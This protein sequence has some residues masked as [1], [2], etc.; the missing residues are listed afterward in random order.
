MKKRIFKKQNI[1]IVLSIL[2]ITGCC[3]FYGGRFVYY[4]LDS[5]KPETDKSFSALLKSNNMNNKNFKVISTSYYF[6]DS[7][8]DNYVLYSGVLFRAFKIDSEER[9]YLISDSSVTSLAMG[10]NKIFTNS[11]I[12]EWLNKSNNDNSGILSKNLVTS[13]LVNTRVCVD[14]KDKAN[15]NECNKYVSDYLIGLLDM[16]DYINMGGSKSF[17]NT[18][19]DFYLVNNNGKKDWYVTNSGNVAL[20]DGTNVIGVKPVVSLK[21]DIQVKSGSGKKD[22]PYVIDGSYFGSY[23]KLG[24]DTWRVIGEEENNLRLLLTDYLKV[25]GTKLEYAYSTSNY[26]YDST[27]KNTLAYYLNHTYLNSLS[28]ENVIISSNYY[29]G[30]YGADNDYDYKKTFATTVKARVGILSIG[31]INLN[32]FTNTALATGVNKSGNLVY[33]TSTNSSLAK[34]NVTSDLNVVPVITISKSSLKTGDGTS[35]KPYG[36]E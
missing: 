3:I 4:Y 19:E 15:N 9:I 36:L 16:E 13:S 34:D 17:V 33:V 28:Y 20:S 1:F 8:N 21:S 6:T 32:K 31:D 11:Y 12:K 10:E 23:V 35:K 30:Y 22:D 24:N 7:D 25:N 2:F 27:K 29:N 14:K 5:K 26:K 18:G